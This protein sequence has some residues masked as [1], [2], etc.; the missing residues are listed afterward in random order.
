MM[1]LES[2]NVMKSREQFEF[3][4]SGEYEEPAIWFKLR[5]KEVMFFPLPLFESLCECDK[6]RYISPGINARFQIFPDDVSA[7]YR[8]DTCG[9]YRIEYERDVYIDSAI[10][11]LTALCQHII[12]GNG[13]PYTSFTSKTAKQMLVELQQISIPTKYYM[14][15]YDEIKLEDFSFRFLE[16]YNCDTAYEIKIGNRKYVSHISDW[17]TSFNLLRNEIETFIY[18]HE[19]EGEGND[20]NLFYEDSPTILRLK[21]RNLFRNSRSFK[22]ALFVSVIPDEFNKV[23]TLFAWC[24]PKQLVCSFYLGLLELFT[25]ETDYFDDGFD[26]DMDSFRVKSYNQLQ[27]NVIEDYIKGKKEEACHSSRNRVVCSVEEM[28]EDYNKLKYSLNQLSL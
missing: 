9:Y 28:L 5:E 2:D 20:I 15:S 22:S 24:K 12:E 14:I 17:T 4:V 6:T 13:T 27:S 7:Y 8:D 19:S 26:G 10:R 11:A 3:K 21:M 18:V 23:P 25:L 16:P 1:D